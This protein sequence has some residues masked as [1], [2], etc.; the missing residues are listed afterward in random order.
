MASVK[1]DWKMEAEMNASFGSATVFAGILTFV[2]FPLSGA[3]RIRMNALPTIVLV[4]GAFHQ[5]SAMDLLSFQLK[6]AG[7]STRT[8]GLVTVDHPRLTVQDDAFALAGDVLLPL[9]EQQGKDVVLYLHS[10]A[11]F[12]GSAAIKGLSK[13]ERLAAGEQGGVLGLIFQSAFI[14]KPGDTLLQMI[15]GNYAPWHDPNVFTTR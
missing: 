7:Y 4:P 1:G 13:T 14:P 6:E 11:G 2:T 8:F 5:A 15:G 3:S 9:I 12:P 10:Y